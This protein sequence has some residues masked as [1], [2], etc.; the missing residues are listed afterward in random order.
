MRQPMAC[1]GAALAALALAAFTEP[2]VAP[3]HQMRYSPDRGG[4]CTVMIPYY[5]PQRL[6]IGRFA[7]G[8]RL[9]IS[10]ERDFV[11]WRTAQSCF[12]D[13]PTCLRWLDGVRRGWPMTPG[14]AYCRWLAQ[15][16][17]EGGFRSGG[18]GPVKP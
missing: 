1:L 7:G 15:G 2:P 4:D 9:D 8:R 16:E 13:E 18:R 5:G 14:Y 11:D 6:W 17:G 3:N 10:A 12:F